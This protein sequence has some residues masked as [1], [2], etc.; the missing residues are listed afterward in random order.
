MVDLPTRLEPVTN[1]EPNILD[2]FLYMASQIHLQ[3]LMAISKPDFVLANF[4]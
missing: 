3:L 1:T 2:S 4:L